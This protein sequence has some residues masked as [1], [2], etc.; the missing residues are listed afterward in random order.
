MLSVNSGCTV[1]TVPFSRDA[2]IVK[3]A[4]LLAKV[5][6]RLVSPLKH[7]IDVTVLEKCSR[8]RKY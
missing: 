2:S 6:N 3:G 4:G 7:C 8:P 1:L 5:T